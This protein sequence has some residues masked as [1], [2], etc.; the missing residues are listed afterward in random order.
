MFFPLLP[1]NLDSADLQFSFRDLEWWRL[2]P[3]ISSSSSSNSWDLIVLEWFFI[4]LCFPF[5]FS[6]TDL[7][8][9]LN[10][11]FFCWSNLDSYSVRWSF[12]ARREELLSFFLELIKAIFILL[13]SEKMLYCSESRKYFPVS[14]WVP[15]CFDLLNVDN[16]SSWWILLYI[17]L[18][19]WLYIWLWRK[20]F[21]LECVLLRIKF[22]R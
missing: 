14:F 18:C 2:A 4:I 1:E 7:S 15:L 8:F 22:Y 5:S 16:S 20:H 17:W 13:L 19:T 9:C 11:S 12:F 3:M 6:L 21:W 10:A